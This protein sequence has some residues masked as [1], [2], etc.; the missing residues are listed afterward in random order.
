[1]AVYKDSR[2]MQIP[3]NALP[4]WPKYDTWSNGPKDGVAA[5]WQILEADLFQ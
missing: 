4:N 3:L 1:M 2:V 5:P